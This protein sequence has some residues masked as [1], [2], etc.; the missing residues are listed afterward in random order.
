MYLNMENTNLNLSKLKGVIFDLDGVIFDIIGS[1][2]QSVDDAI[3]K[4]KLKSENIEEGLQEIAH[5]IEDLQNYPIP[6][7]I[8]N[9]YDLLQISLLEGHRLIKKLRIAVYV[10]NQF[11][12]YKEEASIFEGVEELIKMLHGKHKKLAILTNNK[13]T[14]AEEVLKRFDLDKYFNLI[15]GFN[16]V[17]EVKPSPEGIL[18]ILETWKVK[19]SDVVFI[20]DMVTDILAGQAANVKTISIASGLAKKETLL[21]K[22][23]DYLVNNTEELRKLFE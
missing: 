1:I 17:S 18:K 5:L 20:G 14:H 22:K 21:E 13:N 6:Q 4:Y 3:N 7:I 8:L 19:D 12:K 15:I 11:N 9:S 2:Q 23:P 10:F 16:E